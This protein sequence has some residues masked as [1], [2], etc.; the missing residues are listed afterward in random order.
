MNWFQVIEYYEFNI[1]LS[2][3][4]FYLAKRVTTTCK[5]AVIGE[6]EIQ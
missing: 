3:Y 1:Y 5:H 4:E 6:C 2:V